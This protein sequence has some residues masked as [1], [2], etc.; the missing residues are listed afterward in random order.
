MFS[1]AFARDKYYYFFILLIAIGGH[2]EQIQYG[3]Y[4]KVFLSKMLHFQPVHA[5][6]EGVSPP[7]HVLRIL[8]PSEK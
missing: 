4:Y 3:I 8:Q 5:A 2:R 7:M 1:K 6:A